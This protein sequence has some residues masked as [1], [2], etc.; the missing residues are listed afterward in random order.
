MFLVDTDI[1]GSVSKFFN[2]SN[3]LTLQLDGVNQVIV[4]LYVQDLVVADMY[5]HVLRVSLSAIGSG[6]SLSTPTLSNVSETP[7]HLLAPPP[8]PSA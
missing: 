1:L 2:P 7:K 4:T 3:H 8:S 6:S 5:E